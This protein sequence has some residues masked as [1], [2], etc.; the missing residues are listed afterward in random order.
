MEAI[1]NRIIELFAN[2]GTRCLKALSGIVSRDNVLQVVPIRIIVCGANNGGG[3]HSQ[4]A[5]SI[6]RFL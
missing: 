2:L 4:H 3:G 1:G 5:F 6:I